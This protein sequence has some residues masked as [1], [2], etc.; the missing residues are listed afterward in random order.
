VGFP[1]KTDAPPRVG[2][3]YDRWL[4]RILT[5]EHPDDVIR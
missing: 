4:D 1:W 2:T 3:S 5:A